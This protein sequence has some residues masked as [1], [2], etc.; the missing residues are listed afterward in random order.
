VTQEEKVAAIVDRLFERTLNGAVDWKESSGGE[1]VCKLSDFL[2]G[3]HLPNGFDDAAHYVS[4]YD[5]NGML[6]R[7]FAGPEIGRE[8]KLEELHKLASRQASG[9]DEKLD[10]ILA[11]L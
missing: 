9:L 4:L 7:G 3:I 6:M 1:V 8:Q 2:V 10:A 5:H 11:S